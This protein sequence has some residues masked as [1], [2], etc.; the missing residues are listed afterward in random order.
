MTLLSNEDVLLQL[1]WSMQLIHDS[2]GGRLPRFWRP[3]TGDADA[4]VIAIAQEVYGLQTIFW[5]HELSF[6]ASSAPCVVSRFPDP[7]SAL[8]IGPWQR[9]A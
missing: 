7:L 8:K 3:P 6:V 2:T 4:R 9:Q 1:G 5:N